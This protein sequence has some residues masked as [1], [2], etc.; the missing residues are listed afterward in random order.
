MHVPAGARSSLVA[1]AFG[2]VVVAGGGARAQGVD[3]VQVTFARAFGPTLVL[4]S[5][6]LISGGQIEAAIGAGR[7][8]AAAPADSVL[9][10]PFLRAFDAAMGAGPI[11]SALHIAVAVVR[12]SLGPL[13]EERDYLHLRLDEVDR[14]AAALSEQSTQLAEASRRAGANRNLAGT[15]QITT[16]RI[17]P[18]LFES[19]DANH[20][21]ARCNPCFTQRP[22][23]LGATDIE[24]EAREAASVNARILDRRN[25][26]L[27]RGADFN[28]RASLAVE[29]FAQALKAMDA[30]R[31]S[32][33]TRSL[34]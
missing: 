24:R 4:P 18:R 32:A 31:D 2:F 6:E 21:A 22:V 26:I 29:L 33:I 5:G 3:L 12:G 8:M 34:Q 7:A 10:T 23:R 15:T 1:M 17:D 28:R 13:S 27:R 16:V 9:R 30:A 20:H 14:V 19:L 11:D 25:E